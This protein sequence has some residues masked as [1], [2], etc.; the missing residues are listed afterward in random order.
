MLLRTLEALNPETQRGQMRIQQ[1][2]H[3]FDSLPRSLRQRSM[4][5][6][7]SSFALRFLELRFSY[8]SANAPV[9]M[10]HMLA[11]NCSR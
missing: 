1:P 9:R 3:R 11:F 7:F 8:T 5:R 4:K 10:Q 6:A 2:A